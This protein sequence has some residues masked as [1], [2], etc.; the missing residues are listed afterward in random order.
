LADATFLG[1]A[2]VGAGLAISIW[3]SWRTA[4][5]LL[6]GDPRQTWLGA[7]WLVAGMSLLAW[8]L[9]RRGQR[10]AAALALVAAVMA[11]LGLLAIPELQQLW[12]L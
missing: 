2:A 1:L 8:P 10:I 3:W 5:G 4:G 11:L 9:E 12:G 7:T 6:S